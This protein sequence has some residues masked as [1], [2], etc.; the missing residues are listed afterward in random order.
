MPTSVHPSNPPP[1]E[2][3]SAHAP[4]TDQAGG[5]T[6]SIP[7]VDD[8]ADCVVVT[9]SDHRFRAQTEEFIS[10]LGFVSPHILSW[11]SGA[12]IANPLAA[13]MGFL[14]KAFDRLFEKAVSAA[15]TAR[16]ILVA[17]E[18]CAAYK[19]ES[20]IVSV[21]ARSL[22]RKTVREIQIQHLRDAAGRLQHFLRGALVQAFYADVKGD[23]VH[24]NE[25]DLGLP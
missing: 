4:A 6:S 9:C 25:V 22:G 11:P 17:H 24:F 20:K 2:E 21:A 3:V 23:K 8:H 10:T 18:D 19:G 16:I 13:M 5:F 1:K 14:A 7:W 12:T 15:G